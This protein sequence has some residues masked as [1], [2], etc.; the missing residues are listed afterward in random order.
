MLPPRTL[1]GLPLSRN[2]SVP[3]NT[4]ERIPNVVVTASTTPSP[5]QNLGADLVEVRVFRR[6][7]GRV[8]DRRAAP[9]RSSV[10]PAARVCAGVVCVA[11][12][13]AARIEHGHPHARGC[14]GAPELATCTSTRATERRWSTTGVVTLHA[15]QRDAHRPGDREPGVP[16]DARAGIPAAGLAAVVHAHRQHVLAVGDSGAASG[17]RRTRC[18]R[19]G[20]TRDARRSA[21]RRRSDRRRRSAVRRARHP[22]PCRI[23]AGAGRACVKCLR[24]QPTPA[25]V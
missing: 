21:T 23:V 10:A 5:D 3:L 17:R 7:Q 20:E 15:P 11:H 1:Y 6:P 4:S 24:Y 2:P 13:P 25:T 14:G 12:R 8:G 16:V 22:S 9:R 18:S 19:W